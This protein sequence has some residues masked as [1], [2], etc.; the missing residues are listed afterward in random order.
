MDI[1]SLRA[2]FGTTV[3]RVVR[4]PPNREPRPAPKEYDE[5]A[6]WRDINLGGGVSEAEFKSY[7][8]QCRQCRRYMGRAL[9]D[10]HYFDCV[11]KGLPDD[12]FD[13]KE[14]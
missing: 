9:C 8:V 12:G 1:S 11:R 13:V 5:T 2:K 14:H 3:E 6:I 10:L 4:V 7:Y